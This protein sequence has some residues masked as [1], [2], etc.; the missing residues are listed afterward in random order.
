MQPSTVHMVYGPS[1]AG[2]TTFSIEL[3]ARLGAVH[4]S[5][6]RWM[7]DLFGA[8]MPAELTYEWVST[9][10]SRCEALIWATAAELVPIGVNV[11]LDLGFMKAAD[12]ARFAGYAESA[13]FDLKR[14]YLI[15]DSK[16]RRDRVMARNRDQGATYSVEVSPAMFEFAEG[17]FEYPSE[18]EQ[19]LSIIVQNP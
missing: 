13:E 5:I 6:D 12:R 19:A 14:H 1:G 4:F 9:R 7:Q 18:A 11:V 3:A 17:L 15:A 2:K 16:V 8:D 10:V